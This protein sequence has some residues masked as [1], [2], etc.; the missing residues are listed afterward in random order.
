[1]LDQLESVLR[2]VADELAG[3]RARAVKAEAELKEGGAR[4]GGAVAKSD[5][6]T[7]GRVADLEQ[8]NR[9]LRQRVDAARGRVH[10][11]LSRLTFLEEQAR[12][13]GG[14]GG[15]GGAAGAAG[16]TAA[17]GTGGATSSGSG[18]GGGTGGSR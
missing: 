8:E 15:V 7:R 2:Y 11:L 18:G 3:W 14:N 5:P 16:A 6:E 10:D 1:M 12:Q 4:S 17:G 13:A 9:T